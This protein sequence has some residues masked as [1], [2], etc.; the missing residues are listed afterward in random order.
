MVRVGESG[1]NPLWLGL[2]SNCG[3]LG[4]MKTWAKQ[5]GFTIV[6]LLIVIVVI[7][8]L[9]AITI[10][11]YTG[12]Q[13]R[14]TASALQSDV[15]AGFTTLEKAKIESGTETY[16][17]SMPSTL[18]ASGGNTYAYYPNA[19]TN[20]YCLQSSKGSASYSVS[21]LSSTPV[22]GPCSEN[23]LVGW[24]TFN[25]NANDS[26]SSQNNGVITGGVTL[27]TGQNGKANSAYIFDGSTG[28][29]TINRLISDDFTICAWFK[30]S[31]V[32]NSG[33]HYALMPLYDSE[34]AGLFPDFGF[35][36]NSSGKLTYGNGGTVDTS[37]P[38]VQSVNTNSWV[39]GCV[40]RV[41]STG[42]FTLYIDGQPAPTSAPATASS[43]SLT[44]ISYARI[45]YGY[46]MGGT[47]PKY[48]S[49]QID[50]VRVFNRTLT[51]AEI[52]ALYQVGAE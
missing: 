43:A 44:A 25:G 49:G 40:A 20:T 32:G 6:E 7:A 5:S 12:I 19:V 45:G 33:N 23:S 46:D 17:S 13:E 15:N 14:A 2:W 29:I 51:D 37:I 24:Y 18:T 28:Y 3:I 47:G 27:T 31:G 9:A 34:K 30:T 26:S 35:G 50:D 22:E 52:L 41:K 36:V 39:S 11:A 21:S 42:E 48:W 4:V 38:T 1:D 16:P 10:V 8:I